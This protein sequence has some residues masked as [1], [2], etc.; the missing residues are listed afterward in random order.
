MTYDTGAVIKAVEVKDKP[1][2]FNDVQIFGK[3]A[4]D[5]GTRDAAY[6]MIAAWQTTLDDARLSFIRRHT[7]DAV[8]IVRGP[9]PNPRPFS[10][11]K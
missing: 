5:L 1:V 9:G 10:L 3:K 2:T 8:L 7:G 11:P 4:V 6:V